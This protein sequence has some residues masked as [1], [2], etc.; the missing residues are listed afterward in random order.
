M[1]NFI[2][3]PPETICCYIIC[4]A[5][6]FFHNIFPLVN[7]SAKNLTTDSTYFKPTPPNRTTQQQKKKKILNLTERRRRK[8]SDS[9]ILMYANFDAILEMFLPVLFA[10]F[11]FCDVREMPKNFSVINKAA[12]WFYHANNMCYI[13]R[14]YTKTDFSICLF[15]FFLFVFVVEM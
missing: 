11:L 9:H 14:Y 7:M 4:R 2:K 8:T 5:F 15:S 10:I 12:L 6:A 13:D 1:Y 3:F